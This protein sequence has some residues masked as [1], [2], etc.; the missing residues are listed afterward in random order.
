MRTENITV[1]EGM[2][3]GDTVEV[4]LATGETFDVKVP[5]GYHE[6]EQFQVKFMVRAEDH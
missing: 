2:G 4:Q 3:P 6:G 1:P 5:E